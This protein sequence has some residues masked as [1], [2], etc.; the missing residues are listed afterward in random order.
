MA[1]LGG[2]RKRPPARARCFEWHIFFMKKARYVYV[3][4]SL[5]GYTHTNTNV[6]P[7]TKLFLWFR[8]VIN[9]FVIIFMVAKVPRRSLVGFWSTREV[10]G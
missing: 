6:G 5:V 2:G 7:L 9:S 10:L 3:K 1:G 8:L 4:Y